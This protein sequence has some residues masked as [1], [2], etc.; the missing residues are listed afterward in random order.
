MYEDFQNL[1]DYI[2]ILKA[3]ILEDGF[4]DSLGD[5]LWMSKDQKRTEIEKQIIETD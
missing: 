5:I 2:K 4:Q 3:Y 1:D